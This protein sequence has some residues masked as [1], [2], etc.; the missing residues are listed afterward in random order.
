VLIAFLLSTLA[1]AA[2]IRVAAP[3]V[4]SLLAVLTWIAA[5]SVGSDTRRPPY[6]E[7]ARYLDEV[8]D[9]SPIIEV[10]LVLGPDKRIG[11]S[12]LS[13]YFD[14]KHPVY[15]ADRSGGAW[16]RWRAGG[17]VYMVSPEQRAVLQAT[18]LDR[19]P[20]DLLARRA[21]LGGPDGRAIVRGSKTLPGFEPVTVRR[22][23]G[24]VNGRLEGRGGEETI[25]WSLGRHVRVSPG[26]AVGRGERLA[27]PGAPL[28]ANGWAVDA[29]R[30]RP[31]DW[32]LAFAGRRLVGVSPTGVKRPDTAAA[33]GP[34][35]LLSGFT[36]W[37]LDPNSGGRIRLFGVVGGRAS[38][39]PIRE[40]KLKAGG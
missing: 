19:A 18:G 7:A 40:A 31:V 6:R 37:S 22:Y 30:S 5:D 36:F 24:A 10:G 20:S 39:L 12:P 9:G 2:P 27:K 1:T 3:A 8:A 38:E 4:A 25:S 34:G 28:V 13:L 17:D 16:R 14:R 15:P 32:V 29:D 23:Q 26:V 35:S 33:Y 11:R 21:R